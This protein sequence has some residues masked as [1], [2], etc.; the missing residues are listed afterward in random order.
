[1]RVKPASNTLTITKVEGATRQTDAA[2][3]AFTRGH[4][5]IAMTLAGAAEGMLHGTSGLHMSSFLLDM[6]P[7][8]EKSGW[9]AEINRQRDW[10]K[11]AAGPEVLTLEEW[12]A[13]QIIVRAVTKL[14]KWTPRM[15]EFK[16]W[17]VNEY[18]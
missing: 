3:E 16:A 18:Q 14:E 1:M 2:I 8:G 6:I 4:F 17:F 12:Q 15:E 11:H 5:D 9:I 7:K 10:L 13:A